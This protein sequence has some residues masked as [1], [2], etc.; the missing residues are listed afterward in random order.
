LARELTLRFLAEPQHVNFGGKVHGGQVMKWIDQAGYAC[1]SSWSGCYCVTAYVGGVHFD[2]PILIGEL[3]DV[4]ARVILTGRTSMHIAVEV[5]ARH[6][7]HDE[8]HHTTHCLLVFVALSPEMQPI[9]VKRFEPSTAL[10]RAE[11]AYAEKLKQLEMDGQAERRRLRQT[12]PDPS[13][14]QGAS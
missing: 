7:Q 11:W 1:A 4:H 3:V 12:V 2:A 9:P 8:S 13:Q 14:A 5:S 6:P 10:E